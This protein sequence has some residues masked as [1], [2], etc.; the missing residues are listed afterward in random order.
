MYLCPFN[1]LFFK[2]YRHQVCSVVNVTAL[3]DIVPNN[4]VKHTA[5]FQGV[6]LSCFKVCIY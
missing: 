2:Y 6:A 1:L 5:N 4:V 3:S